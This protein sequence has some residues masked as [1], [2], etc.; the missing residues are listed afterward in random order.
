MSEKPESSKNNQD[1][2]NQDKNNQDKNNQDSINKMIYIYQNLFVSSVINIVNLIKSVSEKNN[3]TIPSEKKNSHIKLR[4]TCEDIMNQYKNNDDISKNTDVDQVRIIKKCF[5][6]L[7]HNYKLI[8]DKDV[9]L[10]SVRNEEGKITTII[11]G[12]NIN[13]CI[14][15]LTDEEKNNLW[16]NIESLFVTS[17]KMVYTMTDKSRHDSH[18][19]ELCDQL[20]QKSLKKLNNFFMGLNIDNN[21]DISMDQLM[22]NDITIPGTEANSGLLGK[23]GVDKLMN[24]SALADE[25]KKFDDNDINDTINTL[26]SMLGNDSDVK[27]VCTTMVKSVLADIQKNGLENMF[28][29]AERVSGELNDKIDPTK[30]AKTASGMND[31]INNNKDKLNDLKDDKGN[32]LGADFMKNFQ[33]TL[34]MAKLFQNMN[35]K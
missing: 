2:N 4:Q 19:V 8:K 24:P 35:K 5:K 20:E 28:N 34:N 29:I 33:S 18:I 22:S 25:I 14:S 27:D 21:S 13:L 3:D 7:S 11:P 26:T 30:M 23:L 12:L 16:D 15:L 9:T 32:P 10:F 6:V 17:V 31:L 1:K